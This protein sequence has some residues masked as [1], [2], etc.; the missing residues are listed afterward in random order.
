M[1][2]PTKGV[3]MVGQSGGPTPVINASLA[4][5]IQ[6][7]KRHPEITHVYGLVHG[8]EGALK[9]ELIDLDQE[10]EETLR[11]LPWTPAAALGSCRH[12]LSEAD[13]EHIL[14]VFRAYNVRFFVYIGGNDSMDTCYRISELAAANHYELLVMGVPKTIDNDLAFTDHCPGYGSAARFLALA[15]RDTGRDLEAMATF[16][17]VTILEAMGRNAGWLTAASTLGKES[18]DEAPHLVYVP[19]VPFDEAH[20]LDDVARIHGR[21]GRVFVVVS[22]GIRDA[23]GQFIGQQAVRGGGSDAF[24]HVVHALTTGVAA[25]LTDVVRE[26]LGLQARFLRPGLIGRAMSACVSETDRQEA[27]RVGRDA[28][29]HLAAGRS[30]FTVTLERVSNKPY[31]C[32]TGLARL[33]DVANAEK[34]LPREFV[35]EAGSMVTEAF[36][37]YALP[38]IDG[39]LPPLARLR[40]VRVP[41]SASPT[42]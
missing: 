37:E 41:K 1:T 21:L 39:P 11:L 42:S 7:A 33:S 40:G 25:Y 32:E 34:L 36:R 13:Y 28:V 8:I 6:E 29:S 19:E 18:E 5:I 4:G 16:D 24:G 2:A 15:T 3:L 22:E 27:L 38:L 12:K 17:D 26:R 10:S 23:Q 30:G 31:A 20:F 35:N 9:E 14:S